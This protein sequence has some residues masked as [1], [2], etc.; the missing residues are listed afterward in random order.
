MRYRIFSFLILFVLLVGLPACH[1]GKVEQT[2]TEIAK[3]FDKLNKKMKR[4]NKKQIRK[5]KKERSRKGGRWAHKG[6]QYN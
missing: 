6:G 5:A 1:R 4:A 3:D 2:P